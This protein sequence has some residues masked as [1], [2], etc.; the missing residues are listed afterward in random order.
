MIR[1]CCAGIRALVV[2]PVS[3]MYSNCNHRI[4][5][6]TVNLTQYQKVTLFN[7]YLMLSTILRKHLKANHLISSLGLNIYWLHRLIFWLLNKCITYVGLAHQRGFLTCTGLDTVKTLPNLLSGTAFPQHW[8]TPWTHCPAALPR[9]G[10]DDAVFMGEEL[11]GDETWHILSSPW[12]VRFGQSSTPRH[13]TLPTS[14]LG[15][16][17]SMKRA[18]VQREELDEEEQKKFSSHVQHGQKRTR[19]GDCWLPAIVSLLQTI[20]CSCTWY[21]PEQQPRQVFFIIIMHLKYTWGQRVMAPNEG[22]QSI[23]LTGNGYCR[24][25]EEGAGRLQATA[26]GW[27]DI[28]DSPCGRALSDSVSSISVQIQT[29]LA[30]IY[31]FAWFTVPTLIPLCIDIKFFNTHIPLLGSMACSGKKR[32]TYTLRLLFHTCNG[33]KNLFFLLIMTDISKKCT[34]VVVPTLPLPSIKHNLVA[35]VHSP[36]QCC[37][38]FSFNYT[39]C[40]RMSII[41]PASF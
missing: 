30:Q 7:L 9:A 6:N 14:L 40:V 28:W 35:F 18:E 20:S 32:A 15:R 8:G 5:G 3:K 4:F 10:E 31:L 33:R 23:A 38:C 21:G 22:S 39:G 17:R 2:D 29:L 13:K 1:Y 16:N 25:T 36:L 34:W 11:Q 26:S 41:I 19:G 24:K 37:I 12:W 27:E